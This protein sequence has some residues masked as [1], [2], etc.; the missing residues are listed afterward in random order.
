MHKTEDD[1]RMW[2]GRVHRMR[3]KHEQA[4]SHNPQ[5]RYKILVLHSC[6]FP[7]NPARS[8]F[9]LRSLTACTRTASKKHY[10]RLKTSTEK[11]TSLSLSSIGT[12]VA[13]ST[14]ASVI[15]TPYLSPLGPSGGMSCRPSLICDSIIT[16]TIDLSPPL[17]C[18]QTSSSTF[19][20]LLWFFEE[21]P[22]DYVH[23]INGLFG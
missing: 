12:V 3:R 8:R 16:P 19:G 15:L 9:C 20:W 1:R 6:I 14:H 22:S 18:S 21:L 23:R 17:S 2:G 5:S 11:L 4:I 10:L 7:S 13:Q